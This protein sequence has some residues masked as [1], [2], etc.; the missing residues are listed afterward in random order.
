MT[1]AFS[2]EVSRAAA[3]SDRTPSATE[4]SL[5]EPKLESAPAN[6]DTDEQPVPDARKLWESWEVAKE[7]GVERALEALEVIEERFPGLSDRINLAR[8]DFLLEHGEPRKACAAYRRTVRLAKVVNLETKARVGTVRCLMRANSKRAVGA[9][10]ALERRYDHLATRVELQY[11]LAQMYE[12]R[13]QIS[14]AIAVYRRIDLQHPGRTEAARA[15]ERLLELREQG[16]RV[17]RYSIPEQIDRVERLLARGPIP[18]ARAE[19]DRLKK[20]KM[21]KANR[22]EITALGAQLALREGRFEASVSEFDKARRLGPVLLSDRH[23][24]WKD[25]ADKAVR[26]RLRAHAARAVRRIRRGRPYRRLPKAN[27]LAIIEVG[28]RASLAEPVERALV[29]L[30]R[31]K[32]VRA[33]DLLEGAFLATGVANDELIAKTLA[34]LKTNRKVRTKAAYHYARALQR[35]GLW[36]E[37]EIAF[38]E[39]IRNDRSENH[40]YAMW[41]GQHLE[42]VRA[43][44]SG[45]CGPDHPLDH[46]PPEEEPAKPLEVAPLE[47]MALDTP[48][49]KPGAVSEQPPEEVELDPIALAETLAP[50]AKEHRDAYPWFARAEQLLRLGQQKSATDELHEAYLAWR[51]ATGKPLRRTGVEAVN[52]GKERRRVRLKRSM[53]KARRKLT[54]EQRKRVAEVASSLGDEG[55]AVGF[56]GWGRVRARPYAYAEFVERAAKRH[57]VD[58]NLLFAV[59]RVESVYRRRILSMAGAI[60]LMQIMPRTGQLIATSLGRDDYNA[61]S[62][63]VP[64]VNIEFASWYLAS[65]IERFEGRVPLAIASYNGGPHNVRRWMSLHGKDLP[66][67]VFLEQIPFRETHRYVRRVLTHYAAYRAKNDLPAPELSTVLPA[68]PADPVAF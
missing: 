10:R 13:K 58:P 16:R 51:H 65:L 35:M 55:V 59:M 12:R 21:S 6:P 50:I 24:L 19:I 37:A 27:L 44:M 25:E 41:S 5:A 34:K 40:Y 7:E 11:E 49:E 9:L 61:E 29:A 39:V 30:S 26:G 45:R 67:D 23:R 4:L 18:T 54:A 64:E 2:F 47:A 33:E 8:A 63:L 53:R 22:A 46:R 14:T 68:L 42:Q 36:S 1:L 57:G 52:R 32:R 43:A 62:L 56:G 60:G 17:R 3:W 28:A 15:R 31:A 38:L 66:L 20:V 48:L